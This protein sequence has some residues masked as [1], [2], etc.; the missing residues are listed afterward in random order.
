MASSSLFSV[1]NFISHTPQLL[2]DKFFEERNGSS[3]S[4]KFYC[5]PVLLV[6]VAQAQNSTV[7]KSADDSLESLESLLATK[8]VTAS[9]FSENLADAPGVVIVASREEINRFGGLTL[10]EILGRAAGLDWK[11]SAFTDRSILRRQS[12]LELRRTAGLVGWRLRRLSGSGY[13][14]HLDAEPEAGSAS[15]AQRPGACRTREIPWPGGQWLRGVR[16]LQQSRQSRH[17]S[18]NDRWRHA[19]HATRS[20]R[21]NHCLWAGVYVQARINSA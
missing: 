2:S 9:R 3:T 15:F 11:A 1:N 20:A 4:M 10:R 16:P 14:I 8:V 21:A 18:T 12:R 6:C 5:L 13:R 7:A 17:L 19:V